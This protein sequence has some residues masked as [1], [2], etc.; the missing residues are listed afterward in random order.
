MNTEE[1]IVLTTIAAPFAGA[2]FTW[3]FSL[4]PSNQ[5]TI[6]ITVTYKKFPYAAPCYTLLMMESSPISN[7]QSPAPEER[8]KQIALL[9]N[10]LQ[11]LQQSDPRRPIKLNKLISLLEEDEKYEKGEVVPPENAYH[12]SEKKDEFANTVIEKPVFTRIKDGTD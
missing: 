10:E 7:Q 6:I 11:S 8:K 9:Q 1:I 2:L 4:L 3:L 12:F 5:K